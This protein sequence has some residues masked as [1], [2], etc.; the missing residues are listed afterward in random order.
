[1]ENVIVLSDVCKTYI[2]RN[3]IVYALKDVSM[4]VGKG[5][6]VSIT[7]K[8]GSGKSTGGICFHNGK[9]GFG[10]VNFNEYTR[11]S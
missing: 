10:K 4:K 11:L 3:N 8:S 7:G 5:E 9:V 1:M 6:F 2:S